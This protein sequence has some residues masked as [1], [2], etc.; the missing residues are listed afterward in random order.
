M[1]YENYSVAIKQEEKHEFESCLE[2]VKAYFHED[3]NSG[4]IK[5]LLKAFP[6]LVWKAEQF[7]NVREYIEGQEA[8][9][10]KRWRHGEQRA[11]RGANL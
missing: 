4:A 8:L 3:T 6:E 9:F 7:D 5:K 11:G 1:T 10:E 2:V